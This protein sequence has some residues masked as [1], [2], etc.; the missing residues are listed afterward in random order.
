[1]EKKDQFL[2]DV[3]VLSPNVFN[4]A[5]GFFY[6]SFNKLKFNSLLNQKIEF[7]QDNHSYSKKNVFRGFHYQKPPCEQGKLVRVLQGE[8]IDYVIDLRPTSRNFLKCS[9][10]L[11]SETNKFQLWIPEGFAHAFLTLTD[12][13]H[14]LYKTTNY[15]SK[16]HEINISPFDK[17]LEIEF[18]ISLN[19]L[20]ISPKDKNGIS[21][22]ELK[23]ELMS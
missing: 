18:P 9:H 15:Y 2:D 17:S 7:V 21:L 6:E 8:V 3:L 13:V 12:D 20:E 16:N 14:F 4:D 1:M 23:K 22:G 5:R 10:Y 11:I 19:L